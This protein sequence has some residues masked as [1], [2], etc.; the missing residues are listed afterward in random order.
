[1]ENNSQLWSNS[2]TNAV[3]IVKYNTN[4]TL[5]EYP[6]LIVEKIDITATREPTYAFYK[7]SFLIS[8]KLAGNSVTRGAF[9]FFEV[10]VITAAASITYYDI[11]IDTPIDFANTT[12]NANNQTQYTNLM[13]IST[14]KITSVGGYIVPPTWSPNPQVTIRN[15]TTDEN[16]DAKLIAASSL[17]I[18]L[19][20]FYI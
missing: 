7:P 10:Q 15:G 19:G 16:V 9:L 20:I 17:H 5:Y 12:L 18:N 11:D 6:A 1:M 14:Y 3:I 13:K 4:T 2:S 8:S